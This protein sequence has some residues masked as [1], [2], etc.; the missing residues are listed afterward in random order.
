MQIYSLSFFTS[1]D[2]LNQVEPDPCDLQSLASA[3]KSL[4]KLV[5]VVHE[6]SVP[7]LGW[8]HCCADF[9]AASAEGEEGFGFVCVFHL[10]RQ[11]SKKKTFGFP[12]DNWRAVEMVGAQLFS[13]CFPHQCSLARGPPSSFCASHLFILCMLLHSSHFLHCFLPLFMDPALG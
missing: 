9:L 6:D 1:G 3:L 10:A 4:R 12:T 11:H 7:G 5:L 13:L 8:G 2:I